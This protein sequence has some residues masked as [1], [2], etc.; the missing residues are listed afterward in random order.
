LQQEWLELTYDR[1]VVPAAVHVYETYNPGA[2]F[3][4]TVFDE[5]GQEV[6]AWRGQDPL[7]Q[8]VAPGTGQPLAGGVAK[9]ALKADFPT[10]RVKVYIDSPRVRSWNEIDAVGLVDPAGGVQWATSVKASS[11]YGTSGTDTTTT[12]APADL[13]PRWGGLGTPGNDFVTNKTKNETRAVAAYGW[14]MLAFWDERDAGVTQTQAAAVAVLTTPRGKLITGDF[15]EIGG[16]DSMP[17]NAN[18]TTT[19]GPVP[20]PAPAP[21]PTAQPRT[22][23]PMRPIWRGLVVNTLVFAGAIGVLHWLAVWP[24]RLTREVSRVRGGRCIECGYDL[25]YDYLHGCPECGWRRPRNGETESES[26]R[27]VEAATA[28]IPPH[29]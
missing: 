19:P 29:R 23:M 16:L 5:A 7:F 26:T 2:V 12:P 27:P 21:T 3:R 25:G 18:P 4:V 24:L 6:E 15:A 11:V 20:A 1:A 8:A 17:L 22:R 13:V 14:P 9:I 28:A 10:R